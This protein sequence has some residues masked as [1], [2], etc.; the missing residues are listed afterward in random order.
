[1]KLFQLSALALATTFVMASCGS[2]PKSDKAETGE[3]Q[4][5]NEVAEAAD[6]A[7]DLEASQIT[8]VGTKPVGKHN[9][10]IKLSEGKL[11]L[12]DG[13]IVGGNFV[14]DLNTL[15]V[16]DIPAED[17]ANAKLTGHL[18]SGDFFEVEKFPTATF[19][20]VSVEPYQ[21]PEGDK[22]E[23]KDPEYTLANPT[24]TITGN[25]EMKG[26]KKSIKFPAK[27]TIDGNKVTAEAKFNINR[28]DWGMSYGDDESLGDKFIR[29]TV[30][31]GF[32]I[33]TK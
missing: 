29:P 20:V 3:A 31:I 12:K 28:K 13:A 1:M 9:G 5:V 2:A 16:L 4:E 10:T 7:L 15:T 30:H 17:E 18:K 26:V 11:S 27:V 33:A 23:E 24:H 22:K 32:N 19:E 25:L 21:A 14:I 8:W 6:V